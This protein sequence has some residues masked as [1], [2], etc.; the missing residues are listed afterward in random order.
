MKPSSARHKPTPISAPP[1]RQLQ[2]QVAQAQKT[3]DPNLADLQRQL[4]TISTWRDTLFKGE[5]LRGLLLSSYGISVFGDKTGR[6]ALVCHL[7]TLLLA[8]LSIAGFAHAIVI[9][10]TRTLAAVGP[11]PAASVA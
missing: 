2:A 8:L 3:N 6:A 1:Q 5:T 11:S 9:P 4:T 7:A 10:K